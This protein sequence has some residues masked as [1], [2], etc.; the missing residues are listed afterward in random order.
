MAAETDF[1][2]RLTQA[3]KSYETSWEP[4]DAELRSLSPTVTPR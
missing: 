1:T 4:V 2:S 3:I